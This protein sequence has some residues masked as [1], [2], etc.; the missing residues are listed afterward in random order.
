MKKV[1]LSVLSVL[2]IM[3][4][5]LLVTS[6]IFILKLSGTEGINFFKDYYHERKYGLKIKMSFDVN[7]IYTGENQEFELEIQEATYEKDASKIIKKN[8]LELISDTMID[9]ELEN[10]LLITFSINDESKEIL[11]EKFY[12]YWIEGNYFTYRENNKDE[13]LLIYNKNT[14]TPLIIEKTYKQEE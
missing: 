10:Y 4:V 1:L 8:D 9:G 2:L 11:N 13:I 5:A 7:E 14:N 3:I 12:E 6:Y